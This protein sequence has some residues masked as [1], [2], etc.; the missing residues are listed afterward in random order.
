MV[1]ILASVFPCRGMRRHLAYNATKCEVRYC[2]PRTQW[3]MTP[4]VMLFAQIGQA[5][6]IT[7]IIERGTRLAEGL[8]ICRIG[9][10]DAEPAIA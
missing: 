5:E 1:V 8:R 3:S 7:L 9:D 2:T 6:C 10:E 4:C